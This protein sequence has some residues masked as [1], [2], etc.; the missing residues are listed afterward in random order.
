MKHIFRYLPIIV[1]VAAITAGCAK[2]TTTSE[3]EDNR[4]YFL[5]WMEKNYPG[6]SP[7]SYGI[8]VLSNQ[9]GKGAL[10][11]DE[12][13][14]YAE[15]TTYD[16]EGN[17][18]STDDIKLAQQLGTYDETYYYGPKMVAGGEDASAGF[19][20]SLRGMKVGGRKKVI[21]PFWFITYNRYD[22]QEQY[23]KKYKSSPSSIMYDIKLID[24][25]DDIDKWEIDSLE[26]HLV[27]VYGTPQDSVSY[28]LY[29]KQLVEPAD[30]EELPSDTTVYINYTGRLLNG[31]VFDTNIKK[32]AV[33]N[34]IYSSSKDYE[35]QAVKLGSNTEGVTMDGSSIITGFANMILKMHKYEKGIGYF[36]SKWG[37]SYSG[38][39][40]TIPAYSPLCFE[41][42]LVDKP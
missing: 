13:Y 26:T 28:G 12:E 37:Y 34:N 38:S 31:H 9:E 29:Y 17:I 36:I 16:I 3:K 23:F 14:V 27:H 1:A 25:T 41:I 42:E 24:K 18:A 15:V 11:N 6:L 40:S 4:A 21:V 20:Y 8:Y 39:G 35:P 19:L 32:V 30:L 2:T 5:A 7:D 33:D 10:Y 22:S